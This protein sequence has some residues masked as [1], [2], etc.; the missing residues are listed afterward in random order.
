VFDAI[1]NKTPL[2]KKSNILIGGDAPSV[3]LK[4]IEA[5]HGLSS[6]RLDGTRRTHLIEPQ[7]AR[8]KVRARS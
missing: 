3:Y 8:D 1:V 7:F 6:G 4:R 2:S 5:K